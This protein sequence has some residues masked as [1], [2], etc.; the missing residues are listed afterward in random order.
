VR[1][2]DPDG[3]FA[4]TFTG[5]AA[6]DYFSGLQSRAYM[7]GY[8]QEIN[9]NGGGKGSDNNANGLSSSNQSSYN[10]IA[11]NIAWPGFKVKTVPRLQKWGVPEYVAAGHS[12]IILVNRSTG[13]TKYYEFGRYN[14][15]HGYGRVRRQSIP[16]AKFDE[17]GNITNL[18]PIL[19]SVARKFP[20]T[21]T[22]GEK[23]I[24][25][26]TYGISFADGMDYVNGLINQGQSPYDPKKKGALNCTRFA[27]ETLLASNPPSQVERNVRSYGWSPLPRKQVIRA[28]NR[29]VIYKVDLNTMTL[30][31][32]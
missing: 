25:S 4:V 18:E 22:F 27:M 20:N 19:I 9:L 6:Q 26:L 7:F 24:A 30:V 1:V 11:I 14:T 2:I 3:A 5:Q 21:E 23:M 17:N 8:D 16:I 28:R 10:D 12:A 32:K 13:L 15:K 29:G 31:N